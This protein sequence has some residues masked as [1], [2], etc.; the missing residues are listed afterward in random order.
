[1][2][3]LFLSHTHYGSHFR[4][5]SHHLYEQFAKY[6]IEVKHVSTPF[7]ILH[8][9]AADLIKRNDVD[10]TLRR[11]L[12]LKNSMKNSIVPI[13]IFP[14]NFRISQFFPGNQLKQLFQESWDFILVDQPMFFRFANL[15]SKDSKVV[16]RL[17]DIPSSGIAHLIN[18]FKSKISG[19]IVTN[20]LIMNYI[21]VDNI[22]Y[23]VC[24]N[25]YD[26]DST[27]Q[28]AP[29]AKRKGMVYIG[30]IDDRFDFDFIHEL[31]YS[32]NFEFI[33]LYGI[34]KIP[35]NLPINV[36]YLG[37]LDHSKV[38]A[39]C[40]SYEFGILPFRH[41][42]NFGRS[43]IKLAEYVASGLDILMPG[44]LLPFYF[45]NSSEYAHSPINARDFG[46]VDSGIV[47]IGNDEL[48]TSFSSWE[49]LAKDLLKF[50]EGINNK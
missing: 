48:H 15:F 49:F 5:G 37:V 3:I 9:L 31:S 14:S 29:R 13:T 44:F 47:E 8:F 38:S 34:G 12:A 46:R 32:S 19:V 17:T 26:Y 11:K 50:L 25:G 1:M 45:N 30:A 39:V 4:V 33:H 41:T 6:G 22:P 40:S 24:R 16:L 35:K 18:R 10:F 20:R 21:A 28:N 23:Y 2:K 7:S 27:V 36:S 43:P 42:T